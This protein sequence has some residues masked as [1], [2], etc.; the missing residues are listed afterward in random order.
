MTFRFPR[1]FPSRSTPVA[2]PRALLAVSLAVAACSSA[3]VGSPAGSAPADAT[4]ETEPATPVPPDAAPEGAAD[5]GT[6]GPGGPSCAEYVITLPDAKVEYARV[7][8]TGRVAF[9]ASRSVTPPNQQARVVY[10]IWDEALC[11]GDRRLLVSEAG[12]LGF[13]FDTQGNLLYFGPPAVG[14]TRLLRLQGGASVPAD[15]ACRF[16]AGRSFLDLSVDG[17]RRLVSANLGTEEGILLET[18]STPDCG[19]GFEGIFG[20]T[21]ADPMGAR[22][23]YFSIP[24]RLSPD[25]RWSARAIEPTGDCT[26]G[27]PRY[28]LENALHLFDVS[29]GTS[30]AVSIAKIVE[31]AAPEGMAWRPDGKRLLVLQLGALWEVDVTGAVPPTKIRGGFPNAPAKHWLDVSPDGAWLVVDTTLWKL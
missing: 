6:A 10:E 24:T 12:S 22:Q 26:I 3:A 17:T 13:A 9:S 7:S 11:G 27:D 30:K 31:C 16:P 23:S 25:G 28:T 4:S 20:H 21:N 5:A 29:S 14:G 8:K 19:R 15:P 18:P 2:A 1:P